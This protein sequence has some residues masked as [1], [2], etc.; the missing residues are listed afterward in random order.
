MVM[1]R[2]RISPVGAGM[3]DS[4]PVGIDVPAPFYED[5]RIYTG[6]SRTALYVECDRCSEKLDVIAYI[7]CGGQC[8]RCLSIQYCACGAELDHEDECDPSPESEY[9]EDPKAW[10]AWLARHPDSHPIW[11]LCG[12]CRS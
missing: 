1:S 8:D 6:M 3:S 7:N 11:R 4:T 10:E 2:E 5:E 12:D 9:E